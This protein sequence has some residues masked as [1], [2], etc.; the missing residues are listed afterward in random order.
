VNAVAFADDVILM[1]ETPEGLRRTCE[2]FTDRI[3]VAGLRV[4]PMKCATLTLVPSG[5]GRKVKTVDE[6]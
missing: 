4:N 6:V 2:A 5:R 1:A 3:E